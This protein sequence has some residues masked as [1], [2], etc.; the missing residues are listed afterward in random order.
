M[1]S[2]LIGDLLYMDENFVERYEDFPITEEMIE[3]IKINSRHKYRPDEAP[4]ILT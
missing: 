3:Q 4:I 2:A 1:L